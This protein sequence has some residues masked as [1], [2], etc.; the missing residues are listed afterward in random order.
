[1]APLL[2]YCG[3]P[4]YEFPLTRQVLLEGQ[5]KSVEGLEQ[6]GG[7][8]G[9]TAGYLIKEKK[10]VIIVLQGNTKQRFRENNFFEY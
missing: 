2:L 4:G 3:V 9:T 1:M 6:M 7:G 8:A 10:F 5:I